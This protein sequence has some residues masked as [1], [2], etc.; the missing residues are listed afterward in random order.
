MLSDV[1]QCVP[2]PLFQ[3]VALYDYIP[4]PAAPH[5]H[6]H[7]SF[8][9]GD[10]VVTYGPARPDGLFNGKVREKKDDVQGS[11]FETEQQE[12]CSSQPA[13]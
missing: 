12:I 8:N 3:N 4:S 1:A 10:I 2:P 6:Q 5:P 7:L 11:Q 9:A 13:T